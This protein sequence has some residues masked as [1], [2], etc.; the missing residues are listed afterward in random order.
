MRISHDYGKGDKLLYTGKLLDI[1]ISASMWIK[2]KCCVY[3]KYK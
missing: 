3:K 1:D 2:T